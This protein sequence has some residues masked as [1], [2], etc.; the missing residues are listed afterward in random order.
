[1][2]KT[3]RDSRT[4]FN[5]ADL[6]P[7]QR[8]MQEYLKKTSNRRSWQAP[9]Y[10]AFA[11]FGKLIFGFG[12]S[13]VTKGLVTSDQTATIIGAVCSIFGFIC[14]I[15]AALGFGAGLGRCSRKWGWILKL[16][17]IFAG[18]LIAIGYALNEYYVST[19]GSL[20]AIRLSF[21]PL[22]FGAAI[23]VITL[24]NFTAYTELVRGRMPLPIQKR[25]FF[26]LCLL[27]PG[28]GTV[29]AGWITG[30][31]GQWPVA[32]NASVL[33]IAMALL[34]FGTATLWS[35]HIRRE[36]EW[37]NQCLI[38]EAYMRSSDGSALPFE[39][40]EI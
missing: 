25:S 21:F 24:P 12:A 34:Y 5:A 15:L 30:E 18:T 39:A 20:T 6:S 4:A 13:Q 36:A 3:I 22:F 38:V 11:C 16:T 35:N 1:M 33:T 37:A 17:S 10:F 27:G 9:L 28:L 32:F 29:F 19:N 8:K 2:D 7:R 14:V 26:A 40:K 23:L 31:K